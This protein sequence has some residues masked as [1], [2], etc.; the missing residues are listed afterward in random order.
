MKTIRK[1]KIEGVHAELC[2]RG[3]REKQ[4][5]RAGWAEY[6][7]CAFFDKVFYTVKF[8]AGSSEG[9]LRKNSPEI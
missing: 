2:D 9:R 6:F 4:G 3:S 7:L 8:L 1:T 5:R